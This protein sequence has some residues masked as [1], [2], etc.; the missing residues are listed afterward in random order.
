MSDG[1]DLFAKAMQAV[2]PL[3]RAD[4]VVQEKPPL[5]VKRELI[6]PQPLAELAGAGEAWNLEQDE[7]WVFRASGV[8]QERLRKLATGPAPRQE[9][10]LHGMTRDHALNALDRF[11]E[12]N[13]QR[14]E[15][16]IGIVHGRGLHS[17]GKAVLKDAVYQWLRSGR[18]ATRILAVM[19][20]PGSGGGACRVLLRRLR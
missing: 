16:A 6:R 14:G 1:E 7:P 4:K 5:K 2:K 11:V 20:A 8:S 12:E 15:R 3:V 19:P 13:L 17:Q 10:D 9:I 18:F